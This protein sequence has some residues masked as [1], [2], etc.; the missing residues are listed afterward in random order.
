[1][2]LR[3]HVGG[4]SPISGV[5][6]SLASGLDGAD[7]SAV[8]SLVPGRAVIPAR[9]GYHHARINMSQ[10]GCVSCFDLAGVNAS[11]DHAASSHLYL[12]RASDTQCSEQGEADAPTGGLAEAL[13]GRGMDAAPGSMVETGLMS[14]LT[15]LRPEG[16]KEPPPPSGGSLP[17]RPPMNDFCT[18]ARR[19]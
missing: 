8:G 19:K 14:G 15:E 16:T 13:D 3:S 17:E 10:I 9:T 4:R 2:T 6:K 5:S 11:S 12:Y 18:R 1:M 7:N